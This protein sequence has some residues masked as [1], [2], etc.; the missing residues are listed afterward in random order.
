MQK[1]LDDI[2]NQSSDNG[3]KPHPV[4]R[5]YAS[6]IPD[7]TRVITPVVSAASTSNATPS[8]VNPPIKLTLRRNP[9]GA[10]V[11]TDSSEKEG[12]RPTKIEDWDDYCFVC[13]QGCDATSGD[14]VCCETC[15]RVYHNV[16]HIPA[17]NGDVKDLP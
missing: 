16:C 3:K 1:A 10:S 13:N 12:K 14:L 17:I 5:Q 15:P 9:P 2:I 6:S 8:S 4:L 7:K 11:S